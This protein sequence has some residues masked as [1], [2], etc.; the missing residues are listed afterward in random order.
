[1]GNVRRFQFRYVLSWV[2]DYERFQ[3]A[4]LLTKQKKKL[5]PST[6]ATA[7]TD[8]HIP[9]IR[10]LC[11]EVATLFVINTTFTTGEKYCSALG[12]M[13][14]SRLVTRTSQENVLYTNG[15]S[16]IRLETSQSLKSF[17][18]SY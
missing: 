18:F 17:V 4:A 2:R 9:W 5:S 6:L 13:N 8:I 12:K 15:S 1:M 16:L 7:F 3:K 10:L 14:T 11:S